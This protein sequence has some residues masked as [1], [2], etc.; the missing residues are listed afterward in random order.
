[1]PDH[2]HGIVVLGADPDLRPAT[3]MPTISAVIRTFTSVSGIDGNRALG[4]MAQPFWQRSFYDRFIRDD[5]KLTAFRR[6]I[7]E[8]P[9]RGDSDADI[10]L[11]QPQP[12]RGAKGAIAIA[13]TGA[14]S[15]AP[16]IP[17]D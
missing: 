7:T 16:T 13:I 17:V 15:G 6:Y 1:M 14:A 10:P 8:N 11:E 12:S 4:R 9:I 3:A 2:L 5:W